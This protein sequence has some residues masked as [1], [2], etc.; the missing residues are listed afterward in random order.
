[1]HG[2]E[3][4]KQHAILIRWAGG[5]HIVAGGDGGVEGEGNRERDSERGVEGLL[6]KPA[7]VFMEAGVQQRQTP[8][9]AGV[10][11]AVFF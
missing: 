6:A 1:M 3:G 7:A 4:R 11:A 5:L 8:A 2:L 10:W 9:E